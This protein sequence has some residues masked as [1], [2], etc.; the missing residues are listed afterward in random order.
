M[1]ISHFLLLFA[2]LFM[3]A[4]GDD[5]TNPTPDNV[6]RLDG[7]NN[8]G[9]LLA[10]GE[11][12]LAVHFTSA[13]MA[14]YAGQK[15]TEVEFFVG[16]PLPANCRVRVYRGG[17]NTPGTQAYE[18]D[19]TNGLQTLKWNKHKLSTPVDLTGEDLW[20]SVFVVHTNEQQSIGCD[21]GPRKDGGDW[22]FSGSDSQW[23]T[24]QARTNESVNWNIRG[25]VE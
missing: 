13:K 20:I 7:D 25:T 14:D 3:V 23:K 8:S 19:V 15:L 4:C 21:A 17:V 16:Q 1:K 6:L 2:A 22:L 24:Y 12:E 5:D 10:A 9:P 18:F 11:H